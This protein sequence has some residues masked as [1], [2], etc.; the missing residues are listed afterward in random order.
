M[1]YVD[2]FWLGATATQ[3]QMNHMMSY[4]AAFYSTAAMQT[5]KLGL[6]VPIAFWQAVAR[7]G[8]A[9]ATGFKPH[10][11][12]VTKPAPAV[13]PAPA[14]KPAPKPAARA[15]AEKAPAPAK[16]A[17][18][19]SRTAAKPVAAL[20][21]VDAPKPTSKLPSK[22]TLKAAA[23]VTDKVAAVPKPAAKPAEAKPVAAAKPK[24]KPKHKPNPQLLDA[25]R[26]GKADDLTRLSGVGEKL[27]TTLNEFGIYHFDQ[28]ASLNEKGI[29]WIN[30][31]QPGFKALAKRFDLVTQ[32]K[33][34][35]VR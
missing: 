7:V 4:G 25:P 32:A 22:P 27:A 1:S 30:D 34:A 12:R 19:P 33:S 3:R 13:K 18:K 21:P 10:N 8:G 26:D 31:Q 9:P 24:P 17:A 2:D 15:V 11:A 5:F 29:N 23:K 14:A 28:I 20:K 16:V 35:S 6:D